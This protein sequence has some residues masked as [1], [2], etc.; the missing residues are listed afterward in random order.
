VTGYLV[1]LEGN[2]FRHTWE[3]IEPAFVAENVLEAVKWVREIEAKNV[4]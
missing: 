3:S 4:D 1:V 2:E